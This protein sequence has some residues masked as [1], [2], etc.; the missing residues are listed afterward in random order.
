[1]REK[2]PGSQGTL[3][4]IEKTRV[5]KLNNKQAEKSNERDATFQAGFKKGLEEANRITKDKENFIKNEIDH[6]IVKLLMG[7]PGQPKY[8][9]KSL[10]KYFYLYFDRADY[11][12]PYDIPNFNELVADASKSAAEII[13]FKQILIGGYRISD[14][15]YTNNLEEILKKIKTNLSIENG[16]NIFDNSFRGFSMDAYKILVKI[17][18]IFGPHNKISLSLVNKQFFNIKID[19]EGKKGFNADNRLHNLKSVLATSYPFLSVEYEIEESQINIK[20]KGTE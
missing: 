18:E 17:T 19:L 2:I 5:E 12:M 16:E 10:Q 7:L 3:E 6:V 1:M 20:L 4:Q 9:L 11:V 13:I 8:I 15:D 14:N